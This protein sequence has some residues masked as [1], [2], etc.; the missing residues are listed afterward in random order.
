MGGVKINV[1]VA[2]HIPHLPISHAVHLEGGPPSQLYNATA[3]CDGSSRWSLPLCYPLHCL[4]YV[5]LCRKWPEEFNY[6]LDA[7]KGHLP[8]TNCLRGTRLFEA[9][10]MHPAF[11][12]ASSNA[13]QPDWMK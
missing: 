10:M 12:K 4:W 8:L 3:S 6:S 1:G 2:T 5:C 11:E 13:N 7:P 9:I